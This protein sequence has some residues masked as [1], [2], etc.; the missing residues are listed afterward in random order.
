MRKLW[1]LLP[2]L[3]ALM[4]CGQ[5]TVWETVGDTVLMTGAPVKQEISVTL[6]EDTVLPVM[7]TDGGQLYMCRDFDVMVQTLDGGDL[8]R[9]IMEVSGKALSD[10]TV[11][12]TAQQDLRSYSFLWTAGTDTGETVNRCRI[13]DDGNY[14]YAVTAQIPVEK[15]P[16][17]REIITGMLE[18]VTLG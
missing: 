18:T 9:T 12:E 4:G 6:P 10:L 2:M 11:M 1:V 15:E 7:E 17:Y 16:E 8:N 3:F 5:E 14:H 13:L